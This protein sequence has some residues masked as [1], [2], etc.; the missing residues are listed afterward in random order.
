MT[1]KKNIMTISSKVLRRVINIVAG[2]KASQVSA[3]LAEDFTTVIEHNM[4]KGKIKFFCPSKLAEWRART[5]LT[6]EPDT[7]EWIDTFDKSDVFWD[8]GA[9]VGVYSLYA[10]FNG[11]QVLAFEP[12]ASNFYLLSKNIEMNNLADN[13]LAYC[14]ALNDSTKLDKLY[15]KNTD[16]GGSLNAFGESLDWQGKSFSSVFE[17][18]VIGY[19]IDEFIEMFEPQIPNHIKIDVDGNEDKVIHGA[20][21]ILSNTQLKSILIELNTERKEYCESII[22]ILE[23]IGF[24]L[25]KRECAVETDDGEFSHVYNHIFIR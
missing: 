14:M 22:D 21:K 13:V 10:G 3:Q 7:I 18:S 16:L 6:K 25:K 9:N 1:L 4:D 12:S 23:K 11:N 19:S 2:G 5:F 24:R 17:Q 15:M 20:L 8:I